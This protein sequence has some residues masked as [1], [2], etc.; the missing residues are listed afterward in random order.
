MPIV[1]ALAAMVVLAVVCSYA[2][3]NTSGAHPTGE[4]GAMAGNLALVFVLLVIAGIAVLAVI[5]A[6][7]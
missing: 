6:T 3:R 1:A 4:P 2:L 7:R 5:G